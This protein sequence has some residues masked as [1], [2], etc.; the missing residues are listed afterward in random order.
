MVG[1]ME[2]P[3]VWRSQS[4]APDMP[5]AIVTIAPRFRDQN[6]PD[7]VGILLPTNAGPKRLVEAVAEGGA[8]ADG[9]ILG[10]FLASPFLD[11]TR[12]GR[13][14]DRAGVRWIANLPSVEQQDAEF[15]LQLSDVA[16]DHD[17]ELA[18]LSAFRAQGFEVAAVVADAAGAA[19]AVRHDPDALVVVPRIGDFA[20]GFPSLRQRGAAAQ[21]VF[22]VARAAAWTGPV[23][24]LGLDSEV[25][26]ERLW[27]ESLTAMVCRPRS[28]NSV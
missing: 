9:T 7:E 20:A 23:L 13:L 16:L 21:A 17:R 6:M 11:V 28:P 12:E 3:I 25:E 15:A 18:A 24:G 27:P 26:H 19:R 1:S 4:P 5:R 10:L 22:D 2:W 14:L 8:G